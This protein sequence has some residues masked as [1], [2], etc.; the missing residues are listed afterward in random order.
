[1]QRGY[2]HCGP[3][4]RDCSLLVDPDLSCR[5]DERA[6]AAAMS[7]DVKKELL[8]QKF[9]LTTAALLCSSNC[10]SSSRFVVVQAT[11]GLKA[12][13]NERGVA[14]LIDGVRTVRSRS[15]VVVKVP[16]AWA[17]KPERLSVIMTLIEATTLHG[18]HWTPPTIV[19]VV[20][21]ARSC[22]GGFRFWGRKQTMAFA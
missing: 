9:S 1:M 15:I 5:R 21:V 18:L 2:V 14:A 12:G 3:P 17:T 13:E 4:S 11:R 6:A 8:A 7:A 10:C 16:E 19:L 20:S 22:A